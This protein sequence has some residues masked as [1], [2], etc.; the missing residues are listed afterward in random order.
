MSNIHQ[1]AWDSKLDLANL[2]RYLAHDKDCI[3]RPAPIKL[4]DSSTTVVTPLTAAC[5]RGHLGVV[6]LLINMGA[7]PDA[8]S[9]KGCTPLHFA[10]THTPLPDRSAIVK[11]LIGAGAD[12]NLPCD[13]EMN[14]PLMNAI[15]HIKD[16]DV[17]HLLVDNGA[18]RTDMEEALAMK[19][20]MARHLRP[21][22]ER[23][24]THG[25][26]VD[27]IVSMVELCVAYLNDSGFVKG[28][29]DGIVRERSH[30]S[31]SE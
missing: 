20:G 29:V 10:T 27:I 23:N 15:T 19:N 16:K 12:V 22:A 18:L 1:D 31:K 30:T 5:S 25:Q 11:A 8:V 3:N 17:V 9:E 21:K 24:S 26:M 2:R 28:V 13:D 7:D 14:T 4:H 6:K